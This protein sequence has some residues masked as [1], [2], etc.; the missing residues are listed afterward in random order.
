MNVFS[1]SA[2]SS[3]ILLNS[4]L[5]EGSNWKSLELNSFIV[6]I[7]SISLGVI[8]LLINFTVSLIHIRQPFL[9][10][11]YFKVIFSK[12]V[13][14]CFVN[15]FFISINILMLI[16]K[17]KYFWWFLIIIFFF[18]FT[19]FTSISYEC[20]T[21]FYLIFHKG[22]TEEISN[23][24]SMEH[25]LSKEEIAIKKP[26]FLFIHLLSFLLGGG[27]S[28]LFG[29][30]A[31]KVNPNFSPD[32]FKWFLYFLPINTNLI[33][34][35]F[36]TINFV[37]FIFSIIYLILSWNLEQIT[38]QIRLKN[39]SIY[40]FISGCLCLVF[41]ISRMILLFASSDMYL[42]I[43]MYVT[44]VFFILYL[45]HECKFKINCYYVQYILGKEGKNCLS[46]F[47]VFIKILFCCEQ[48]EQPNFLDLN[49][50]FV[51]HSLANMGDFIVDPS[52]DK[53][54]SSSFLET[55]SG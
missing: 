30:F 23:D 31:Y 47:V 35:A 28:I 24:E 2:N 53:V 26:S 15:I 43:L 51:F 38:E 7:V 29:L 48:I 49:N 45:G 11:G 44:S 19:Y 42:L 10:Q 34:T 40:C 50:S 37:Y 9:R 54:D 13:I 33:W 55:S 14:D 46:K 52:L 32:S 21:V 5:L 1:E 22:K 6:N 20:M 8:Y 16:F 27:H 36:F 41:P 18:D 25:V 12:S 39:F 3:T 4:D 17:D